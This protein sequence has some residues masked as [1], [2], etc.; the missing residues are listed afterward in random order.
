[1]EIVEHETAAELE[2]LLDRAAAMKAGATRYKGKPHDKCGRR[3]RFV[4]NGG[5]VHCADQKLFQRTARGKAA[6]RA[7]A[8]A[9]CAR[10]GIR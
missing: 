1:M 6:K 2:Q 9:A 8:L 4:A 10:L 7:A 5:C 3:V